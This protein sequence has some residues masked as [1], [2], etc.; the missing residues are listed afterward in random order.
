MKRAAVSPPIEAVL[1]SAVQF[2]TRVTPRGPVEADE[3]ERV[4]A[5]LQRIVSTPVQPR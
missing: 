2:L 1:Q 5:T 4:I 3:L